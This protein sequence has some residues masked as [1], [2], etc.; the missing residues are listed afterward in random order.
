M[1]INSFKKLCVN[2]GSVDINLISLYSSDISNVKGNFF[3]TQNIVLG[4]PCIRYIKS[5]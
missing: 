2:S 5:L 1:S 3:Q 4:I